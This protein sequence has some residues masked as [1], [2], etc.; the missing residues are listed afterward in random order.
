MARQFVDNIDLNNNQVLNFTFQLLAADPAGVEGKSYYNSGSHVW[1]Y[2][3]GTAWK[4][5]LARAD[6]TGTQLASTISDL[7]ATVQAYPRSSFAAPTAD[8]PWGGFKI[9]G[10]AN[11]VNASDAV[12]KG[13]LD[14]AIQGMT[15]KP[16][17][18][19]ATTAN[20]PAAYA[21]GAAGVGAT[22]T[23]T[24]TGVFSADGYAVNAGDRVFFNFQTAG[25]QNGLY[26]CT[27]AGAVGVQA[28]FTREVDMDSSSEFK[29]AL[30]VVGETSTTLN[31]AIY[32]CNQQAPNVGTDPLTFTRINSV[33]A[34]SADEVTLHLAAGQ[35]SIKTTY[36]GQTSISTLGVVT[37]GTWNAT[38]VD[39]AH[40]GT[41][42]TTAA[43]ALTALGGVAK[44][45]VTFGDGAALSYTITHN[46]N[47]R[48]VAVGV[49]DVATYGEV[50]PTVVHS[51]VNTVTLS[52]SVA[53]TL[54][55]LRVTV[56]G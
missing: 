13:Q 5:P 44:Y 8:T 22:L 23:V 24:A 9:T 41:G 51:T 1:K 35:Y 25:L 20:V 2:Y 36:P 45:A 39:I 38:A 42:Q 28:V 17:A 48:D 40:G 46:L 50:Y 33:T 3:N 55:Q 32:L 21:N 34:Q 7:A 14:G 6:H 56:T 52:F 53:P 18:D 31:G 4:N 29:G 47:T 37:T 49:Y 26:L 43:A 30:V 19:A 12:N 11:G 16:T 10:L 27:T 15:Q 54:N